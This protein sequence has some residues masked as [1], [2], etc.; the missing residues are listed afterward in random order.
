MPAPADAEVLARRT[1]LATAVREELAAAGLPVVPHDG[2]PS[3]AAGAHVYV[4]TLDDESGGGVFVEWEVHFVPSSAA[5]DALS[6]GSRENDPCIQLTGTAKSAMQ[7]AIAEILSAAGY[8]VAKDVNDMAPFQLMVRERQPRSS[9]RAWLD[10]Q[11]TR[12]EETLT[13]TFGNR[14]SHDQGDTS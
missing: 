7:D 4:D 5:V 8:A 2:N 14:T 3:V 13:A 1:A 11:T 10:A 6:T 9:W 12:R